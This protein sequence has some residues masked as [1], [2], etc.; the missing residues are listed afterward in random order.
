MAL[1]PNYTMEEYQ[2]WFDQNPEYMHNGAMQ[3]IQLIEP[4]TLEGTNNLYRAQY[5]LEHPNDP[6]R[7]VEQEIVVKICKFFLIDHLQIIKKRSVV[8]IKESKLCL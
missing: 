5:W 4:L 8:H 7:Y 1:R 6:S 3:H 2:R